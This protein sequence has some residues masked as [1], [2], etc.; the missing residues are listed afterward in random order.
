MYIVSSSTTCVMFQ[1]MI[2][3][4]EITKLL[5]ILI[6][7]SLLAYYTVFIEQWDTKKHVSKFALV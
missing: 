7:H 3:L 5:L 2:T 6:G 1:Y 4:V